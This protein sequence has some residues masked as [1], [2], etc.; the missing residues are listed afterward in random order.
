MNDGRWCEWLDLGSDP[1]TGQRLRK[2]VEAKTKRAA[3]M[4]ATALRERHDRGENVLDKA[5]TLG[6]LLDE[7][8]TTIAREG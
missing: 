2:R 3:E 6:E 8:L 7:W 4:K 1:A 5:R